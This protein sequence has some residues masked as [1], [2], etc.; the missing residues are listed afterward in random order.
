MRFTQRL[1]SWLVVLGILVA[2]SALATLA[3][4]SGS[5]DDKPGGSEIIGST[6]QILDFG[7]DHAVFWLYACDGRVFR[8]NEE[9]PEK[10]CLRGVE[11]RYSENPERILD[12]Y[13]IEPGVEFIKV[14]VD[15]GTI[16]T[17]RYR[18]ATP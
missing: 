6:G 9:A 14:I 12:A 7:M 3:W 2:S 15:N 11:V 8:T 1:S 17:T 18:V 5:E 10:F 13:S 16:E 4:S